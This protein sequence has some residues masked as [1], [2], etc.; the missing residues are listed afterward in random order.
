MKRDIKGKW[1]LER[2]VKE[3]L[4]GRVSTEYSGCGRDEMRG[5]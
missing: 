5:R 4:R 1:D 3:G 2:K